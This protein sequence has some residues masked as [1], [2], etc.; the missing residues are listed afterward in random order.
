MGDDP[1]KGECVPEDEY[2]PAER[3][4]LRRAMSLNTS[5]NSEA[6]R[7]SLGE[8]LKKCSV[9]TP[10]TATRTKHKGYV[11]EVIE[12]STDG[13]ENDEVKE[14]E[15]VGRLPRRKS[16]QNIDAEL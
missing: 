4:K 6:K 1:E 8:K 7:S 15:T 14:K 5:S 13:N 2:S 12:D 9:S 16:S 11:S 3:A 10:P